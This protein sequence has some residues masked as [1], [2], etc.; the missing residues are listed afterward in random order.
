MN[1]D[2]FVDVAKVVAILYCG[3]A[4]LCLFMWLMFSLG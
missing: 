3:F 4:V 1:F 2:F